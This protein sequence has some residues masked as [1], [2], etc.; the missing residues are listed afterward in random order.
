MFKAFLRTDGTVVVSGGDSAWAFQ[1][2]HYQRV[3]TA[4]FAY[5][6]QDLESDIQIADLSP[7]ERTMTCTVYDFVASDKCKVADSE[8]SYCRRLLREVIRR[9]SQEVVM[10]SQPEAAS[11]V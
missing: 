9:G 5:M 2:K 6:F 11:A 7:N 8:Y 3:A 1:R 4:A 10:L